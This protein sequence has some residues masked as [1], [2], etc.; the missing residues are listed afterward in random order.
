MLFDRNL[1][2]SH[3]T[4][5]RDLAPPL[6]RLAQ[7]RLIFGSGLLRSA[8]P[9]HLDQTSST[10]DEGPEKAPFPSQGS[11][12]C[13]HCQ[14][15]LILRQLFPTARLHAKRHM[16]DVVLCGLPGASYSI[17][18]CLPL[19]LTYFLSHR[20]R[21]LSL[22]QVTKLCGPE[23]LIKYVVLFVVSLQVLCAYLLRDTSFFSLK[24]FLTAYIIG[25]TANQNCFLAIH[26]I[27]YNL[28]FRSPGAN[29]L[30][31]IFANLPI[32]IPYSASFR[33][34]QVMLDS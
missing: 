3:P 25:A 20:S 31:A 24:F 2:T 1:D 17:N 12:I 26:E 33:V 28:A 21:I 5:S 27:S 30:I 10:F 19:A 14:P 9:S 6:L 7:A 8:Y 16:P 32:G 4:S 29:R 11:Q 15:E 34:R 22:K 23:P 13:S 18:G